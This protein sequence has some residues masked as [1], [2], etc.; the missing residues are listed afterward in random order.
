[1]TLPGLSH[2]VHRPLNFRI[3]RRNRI[4]GRLRLNS[5]L[6]P[7]A[8]ACTRRVR[9]G[10][11]AVGEIAR[12][13]TDSTRIVVSSNCST[14]SAHSLK[15]SR[16]SHE[17]SRIAQQ[18]IRKPCV[19]DDSRQH[20]RSHHCRNDCVSLRIRLPRLKVGKALRHNRNEAL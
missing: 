12:S 10:K 18:L 14:P 13:A 16:L 11:V 2:T 1:V 17:L 4:G 9:H 20:Y 3:V 19:V 8:P 7:L 15:S 5:A 6:A